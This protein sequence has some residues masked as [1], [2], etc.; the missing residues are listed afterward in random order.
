MSARPRGS[1][2]PDGSTVISFGSADRARRTVGTVA[3]SASRDAEP[4]S[5]ADA[6]SLTQV[7]RRL[8]EM[9]PSTKFFLAE[10]GDWAPSHDHL[11]P[12]PVP[13]SFAHA[14][15]S[16][17][18]DPAWSSLP[19]GM[20]SL[21][22][23]RRAHA[24]ASP[25]PAPAPSSPTPSTQPPAKVWPLPVSAVFPSAA[26][27]LPAPSPVVASV[28]APA[29]APGPAAEDTP[30]RFSKRAAVKK[31]WNSTLEW[32]GIGGPDAPPVVSAQASALGG[33]GAT[34]S[35]EEEGDA[36]A[37]SSPAAALAAHPRRQ[38]D[39]VDALLAN[40]DPAAAAALGIDIA[41]GAAAGGGTGGV[42]V[43]LGEGPAPTWAHLGAKSGR[44]DP[45][46]LPA[47]PV[48]LTHVTK[49]YGKTAS[50]AAPATS[51]STSSSSRSRAAVASASA[52][53]AG[54]TAL[55]IDVD[56]A[57]GDDDDD[58][59]EV[60]DGTDP[61]QSALRGQT[62]SAKRYA[63]VDG[64]R[65]ATIQRAYDVFEQLDLDKV[66]VGK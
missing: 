46:Q 8:A 4:A 61:A 19:S 28:P 41:P 42:G 48:Y 51:L 27:P 54:G 3:D 43:G 2:D 10:T 14:R 40:R 18:A 31:A 1:R 34:S 52:A 20:P 30:K 50:A 63:R 56:T 45:E 58:D 9:L 25:S 55:G 33:G 29:P 39:V 53:A 65:L 13:S 66:G 36:A 17:A 12:R 38:T 7:S 47:P 16:A 49:G 59:D 23:L 6:A 32:L 35:T 44:M 21:L 5:A 11:P 26:A 15:A 37:D 64:T 24:Q 57:P 62:Y 60:D 22:G